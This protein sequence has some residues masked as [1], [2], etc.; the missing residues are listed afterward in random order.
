MAAL[1][2]LQAVSGSPADAALGPSNHIIANVKRTVNRIRRAVVGYFEILS[3]I[4]AIKAG[5]PGVNR[6]PDQQMRV[7]CSLH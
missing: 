5:A 7:C 6:T 2:G 3:E 1:L 4:L